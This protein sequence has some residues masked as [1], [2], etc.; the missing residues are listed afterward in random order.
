MIYRRPNSLDSF[1]IAKVH[2]DTWNSTYKGLISEKILQRR[3]YEV[4]QRRW[5]DRI[6]RLIDK[7]IIYIAE[8]DYGEI[9]AFI[10]AGTEKYNLIGTLQDLNDYEGELMAI[11]V[12]KE[13]QKKNIGF[14]LLS[15]VVKYFLSKNINSMIVWVLKENPSKGFY[16]RLGA[17]YIGAKYLNLDGELYLESAYGWSDIRTILSYNERLKK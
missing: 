16:K 11:Y 6:A 5:H 3:T 2:V 10:M 1:G 12:L 14:R 9:V 13:Y 8:N 15:L 7:E 4:S 17:K